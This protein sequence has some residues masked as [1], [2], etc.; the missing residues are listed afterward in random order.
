MPHPDELSV[1]G[2][3][4]SNDREADVEASQSATNYSFTR[5]ARLLTAGDYSEVFKQNKRYSDNYWTILVRRDDLRS[6]RLGLAIAKKRAKRAVD[7]NKIKRVAREAFR[8][9]QSTLAGLEM[10]VMNR[11]AATKASTADLRASIDALF[12]KMRAGLRKQPQSRALTESKK[13]S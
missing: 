9:Q 10:V 12:L 11:D 7:R 13:A 8:Y 6:P 4:L 1:C 5:S 2:S 3:S